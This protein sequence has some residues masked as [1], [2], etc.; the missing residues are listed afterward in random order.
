MAASLVLYDGEKVPTKA[1]PI[2][3][4]FEIRLPYQTVVPPGETIYFATGL[5]L[6]V[7]P[8]TA[9]VLT[10]KSVLFEDANPSE[11]VI[12]V[13]YARNPAIAIENNTDN[14]ILLNGNDVIAVI[15]IRST[16]PDQVDAHA[17]KLTHIS[18]SG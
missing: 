7:L 14:A 11:Y 4:E 5:Y 3:G 6:N 9:T 12:P 10:V 2:K 1:F 17:V 13:G 16:T 8:D 15:R 18:I